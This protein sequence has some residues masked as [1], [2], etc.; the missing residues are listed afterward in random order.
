MLLT[1]NI[2]D[3]SS[4]WQS[5]SHSCSHDNVEEEALDEEDELI[6]EEYELSEDSLECS[7]IKNERKQ[8]TNSQM[9]INKKISK[10]FV[11]VD[12]ENELEDDFD[13]DE[14]EAISEDEQ[15]DDVSDLLYENN[16]K[17]S[18]QHASNIKQQ[19]KVMGRLYHQMTGSLE[20]NFASVQNHI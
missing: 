14:L 13:T 5:E 3:C 18:Q 20:Q 1:S 8:H 19:M 16:K 12:Q 17:F 7:I 15:I 4:Y 6:E 10:F 2:D 11:N 9:F